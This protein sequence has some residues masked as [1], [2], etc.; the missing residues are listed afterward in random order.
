MPSPILVASDAWRNFWVA[1]RNFRLSLSRR[2]LDYIFIELYGELPEYTPGLPF[3]RRFISIPF[4]AE[5]TPGPTMA[6]LRYALD[7]IANDPKPKGVV[8]R[9]DGIQ[10]GWATAQ[11]LRRALTRFRESG[12]KVVV[13]ADDFDTL[14]YYIASA[15]DQ[16]ITP[17]VGGWNVVGLRIETVF[18]AEALKFLDLEAEVISVSPYKDGG[19]ALTRTDISPESRE[20]L[21]SLL[22]A[23]YEE[24]TAAI[25]QG[26]GLDQEEVRSLIDRAPFQAADAME[27]GLVDK[28]LYQDELE[29][30]LAD[31]EGS[32]RL[33]YI[34]LAQAWKRFHRPVE[35]RS[36]NLIGVISFEGVLTTGSS[37]RVPV[38]VPV[39]L[40]GNTRVGQEDVVD[41]L[42]KA[43]RDGS[44]AAVVIYVDSRGGSALA[45]DLIWREIDRLNKKKP[46][47]I[48]MNEIAAS[49]A[50]YISVGGSWIISQPL[51]LTGSIGVLFVRLITRGLV[52]RLRIN[53]V[54]L[55]R[56]EH[57]GIYSDDR[58]LDPDEHEIIR[59]HVFDLFDRFNNRV[60]SGRGIDENL[61]KEIGEG[62]VWLGSQA[63]E[64][65]LVDQLGDFEDALAKARELAGLPNKRK[66]PHVWIS[67]H[68]GSMLPLPALSQP[69]EYLA[70][71]RKFT[72]E[73]YWM[74][75]PIDIRVK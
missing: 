67:S 34:P 16:I 2:P 13:Y 44:M 23:Y 42:R 73:L 19:D 65:K 20:N 10:I 28:V 62:R 32:K 45:S 54:S 7:L 60:T 47:V 50:Y 30:F 29:E 53:R 17:P 72:E 46:V 33:I 27:S 41:A 18:V 48:Y 71:F 55:K 37:R 68:G 57:A 5:E 75:P 66:T 21:N 9:L 52:D 63:A 69:A 6:S 51:T 61:L 11:G 15:A 26:R 56:G 64:R 40:V 24:L 3:W 14:K 1:F 39:P 8:V 25:A 58:K 35:W 59:K 38:P 12:K 43:E 49:A 4:I 36:G 31:L 74:I 22:D 70:L